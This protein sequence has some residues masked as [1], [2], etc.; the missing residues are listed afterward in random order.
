MAPLPF[1]DSWPPIPSFGS[2][3]SIRQAKPE[4]LC[5]ELGKP[6]SPEKQ[7]LEKYLSR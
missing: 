1:V 2:P 5:V 4:L 7:L 3:V 6:L